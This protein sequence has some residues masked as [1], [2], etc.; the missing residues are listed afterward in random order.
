MLGHQ[1]AQAMWIEKVQMGWRAYK[2]VSLLKQS[3]KETTVV[4]QRDRQN[5]IFGEELSRFGNP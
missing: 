5:S 3:T 1:F 2:G 4:W